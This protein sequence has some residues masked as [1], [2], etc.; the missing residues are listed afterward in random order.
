MKT[1]II[2]LFGLTLLTACHVGTYKKEICTDKNAVEIL[3]IEGGYKRIYKS[4]EKVAVIVRG[5]GGK[6]SYILREFRNENPNDVSSSKDVLTCS[7]AGQIIVEFKDYSQRVWYGTDVTTFA[8][9]EIKD[10]EFILRGINRKDMGVP[11][12]DNTN[13]SDE[14]TISHFIAKKEEYKITF[15]SADIEA[16]SFARAKKPKISISQ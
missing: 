4:S 14:E 15:K 7:I 3:N 8:Y 12:V 1:R 2:T 6:G 5:D 9:V 10:N 13:M 16:T 11:S